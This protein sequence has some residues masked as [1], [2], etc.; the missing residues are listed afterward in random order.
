[1]DRR[2]PFKESQA[3]WRD[4]DSH[5]WQMCEMA[6]GARSTSGVYQGCF[7]VS[8]SF[9]GLQ[10]RPSTWIKLWGSGV[11]FS[12]E[13]ASIVFRIPKNLRI[14]HSVSVSVL[15]CLLL[16]H[17]VPCCPHTVQIRVVRLNHW[18][19]LRRTHVTY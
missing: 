3:I 10:L 7:L 4:S 6:R 2:I 12:F 8:Q 17:I 5:I 16:S 11:L 13:S 19:D 15:Y 18:T 9:F 14:F 1:M